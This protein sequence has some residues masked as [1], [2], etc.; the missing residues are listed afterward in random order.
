MLANSFLALGAAQNVLNREKE[1]VWKVCVWL[2]DH[3]DEKGVMGW[4]GYCCF[5]GTVP[6]ETALSSPWN[7]RRHDSHTVPLQLVNCARHFYGVPDPRPRLPCSSSL[8]RWIHELIFSKDHRVRNSL[9]SLAGVWLRYYILPLCDIY[10]FYKQ[11]RWYS[12]T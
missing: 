4:G 8:R 12:L 9:F 7:N 6:S 11:Y 2:A 1:T 3:T 5:S 10:V